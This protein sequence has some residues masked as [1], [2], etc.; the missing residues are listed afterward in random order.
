[1]LPF[2]TLLKPPPNLI[3]QYKTTF[4]EYMHNTQK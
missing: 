3:D 4:I 2:H 1:M